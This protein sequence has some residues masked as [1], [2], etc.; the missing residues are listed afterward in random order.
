RLF[1]YLRTSTINLP[2]RIADAVKRLERQGVRKDLI[3]QTLRWIEET[4]AEA[5]ENHPNENVREIIKVIHPEIQ[6]IRE[7]YEKK[8]EEELRQVLEEMKKKK[9]RPEDIGRFI[10]PPD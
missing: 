5:K 2:R 7:E 6:R 10:P 1:K 8:L 4:L 3:L 9:I